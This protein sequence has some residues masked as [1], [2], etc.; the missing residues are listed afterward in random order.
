MQ[1]VSPI[2]DLND[3]TAIYQH[4]QNNNRSREAELVM[5]GCN[6]A[7]R[8]SDLLQLK[9]S[10]IKKTHLS[11]R[12]VSY[13]DLKEKKTSKAR[14]IILNDVAM[15]A[16]GRLKAANPTDTYLFQ[17]KG[18]RVKNT[19]KPV[20]RQYISDQLIK[21]KDALNLWYPFNTHSLRKT[22]GYHAYK[23]G[24]DIFVIQKLLNHSSV[25]TT[26]RYIG[27]TNE[28]IRAV[29]LDNAISIDI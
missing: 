10:D 23:N 21:T 14:Q 18:N 7:L 17:A 12:Q 16:I 26:F 3:L 24:T 28:N 8:I 29:Y 9:F 13:V 19:I 20:T 27:I 11:N 6:V 4:L 5:V 2:T 15:S 22:F 25:D 1:D